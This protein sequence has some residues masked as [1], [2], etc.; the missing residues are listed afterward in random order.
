VNWWIGEPAITG[1]DIFDN[2][3]EGDVKDKLGSFQEMLT[4]DSPQTY[5]APDIYPRTSYAPDDL[6][7]ADQN[8]GPWDFWNVG[9]KLIGRPVIFNQVAYFT[10]YVPVN[11][12]NDTSDSCDD[13]TSRVWA[14]DYASFDSSATSADSTYLG[15]FKAQDGEDVTWFPFHNY[16]NMVLS[17]VQVVLKPRCG[18]NEDSMFELRVQ[19][20]NPS[21]NVTTDGAPSTGLIDSM[22]IPMNIGTGNNT[23]NDTRLI[24]VRFDSW[25]IVF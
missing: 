7:T 13:G 10:T 17:G 18:P 4:S 3:P 8:L 22:L 11:N 9:E 19:K 6:S 1:N 5:F 12:K 2:V 20:A 14:L 16:F 21:S 15:K 23:G 25:S 24:T